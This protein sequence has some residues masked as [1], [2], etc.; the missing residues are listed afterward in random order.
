[1]PSK[2]P[3]LQIYTKQDVLDRLDQAAAKLHLET[4]PW[5][6][7]V[8][9]REAERILSDEPDPAEQANQELLQAKELLREA[10]EILDAAERSADK[11]R[12]H[13][14]EDHGFEE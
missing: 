13:L 12:R 2:N 8:L 10:G 11:Y 14:K 5:A 6:L 4:K 1:M 9:Q 7:S 3:R